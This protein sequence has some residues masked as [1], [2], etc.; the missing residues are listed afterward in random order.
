MEKTNKVFT[1]PMT[2]ENAK[3]VALISSQSFSVPWS[4]KAIEQELENKYARYIL[5]KDDDGYIGFGGVWILYDEGQI[6]NIAVTPERRHKGYSHIIVNE[7]I[8]ICKEHNAND[9]TLEVRPSNT[10]A[11]KLYESHGFKTEGIRKNYY[12][13]PTEDGLIMWKRSNKNE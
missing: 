13:H 5:L 12:S 11:L 10:A 6:T 7:L 4:L 9:V 1:E 2:M 8:E 3:E